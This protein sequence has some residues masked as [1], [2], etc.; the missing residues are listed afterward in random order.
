MARLP[1]S[2]VKTSAAPAENANPFDDF[3]QN[4][5]YLEFK[6]HFYNYRIRRRS[7]RKAL[8]VQPPQGLILEI[9]SG[10]STMTE[11]G[12]EI[13]YSDISSSSVRFLK[14]KHPASHALEMSITE[15][16]LKSNSM[17][18][19]VCSE[20]LEHVP[21]DQ[22]ALKELFRILAPGGTMILTVP[23]HPYFYSFDDSFVKHERRYAVKS[24]MEQLR[25]TGFSDVKLHKVAG[26]LDKAALWCA[27]K[28]YALFLDG[29]SKNTDKKAK[30]EGLT[31]L[32]LPVYKLLNFVFGGL[33]IL[34]SKITPLACTSVVMITAS[35][36]GQG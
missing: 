11:G 23:A 36:K 9:G 25:Q 16:S 1:S 2:C 28:L 17:S 5:Y 26:L 12:S 15:A 8:R 34:E 13:I 35:K 31:R 7:I 4:P 32:A 20:V 14:E 6:N 30:G 19:I 22:A 21:N 24:F 3:Y 29:K 10:V 33:V 18:A 27:T